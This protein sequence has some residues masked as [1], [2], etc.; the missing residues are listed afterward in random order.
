MRLQIQTRE[1]GDVAVLDLSGHLTMGFETQDLAASVQTGARPGAMVELG[2][3]HAAPVEKTQRRAAA[4][5]ERK[6]LVRFT[7]G[8][9]RTAEVQ[10]RSANANFRGDVEQHADVE[11]DACG[12]ELFERLPHDP[13]S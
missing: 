7:Q 5:L 11:T 2:C 13:I 6:L 3:D 4:G 10:E 8:Q 1:V 9:R 12:T